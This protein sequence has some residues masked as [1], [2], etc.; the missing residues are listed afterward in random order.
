MTRPHGD[1]GFTLVEVMVAMLVL[2]IV[3]GATVSIIASALRTTTQNAD[4][5]QAASL[6]RTEL[7]RLRGLGAAAVPIG[8]TVSSAADPDFTISTTANWQ[9]AVPG[10]PCQVATTT[11]PEQVN[12]QVHIEVTGGRLGAPQTLDA[13]VPP[14]EEVPAIPSGSVTAWVRDAAATPQPVAGVTVTATST[15]VGAV[16][17]SAVTGPD[18][19][20]FFT[21]LVPGAWTIAVGIAPPV[22]VRPG[23]EASV[24]IPA[25]GVG[26]NVPLSYFVAASAGVELSAGADGFAIPAGLPLRAWLG[27]WVGTV[28]ATLPLRGVTI[29]ASGDPLLWPDPVGYAARLGCLDAG[30]PQ[31]IA[32]TPGAVTAAALP[33]TGVEVLGPVGAAVTVT[34]AAEPGGPCVDGLSLAPG[35]LDQV[36]D[37]TAPPS[38]DG[39]LTT[40]LPAGVWTISVPGVDART[41]VLGPTSP[42]PCT[43]TWVPEPVDSPAPSPVPSESES[44][45]LPVPRLQP[46]YPLCEVAP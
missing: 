28:P 31:P 2:A 12:V 39:R 1:E 18:G 42:A 32:V 5:V 13:I 26:Q 27:S 20:V 33:V 4:R 10:S 41:I 45:P 9:F 38:P 15:A 35:I 29:P 19:C 44:P 46:T 6:A 7:E 24:S 3:A 30:E 8:L 37:P 11:T 43:V 16:S 14:L 21:G 40:A 25:L 22:M 34:H 23:T 36:P 17:R